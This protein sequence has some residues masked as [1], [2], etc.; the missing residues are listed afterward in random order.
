VFASAN[1][2]GNDAPAC[3]SGGGCCGGHCHGH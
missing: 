3:D 2:G 1:A